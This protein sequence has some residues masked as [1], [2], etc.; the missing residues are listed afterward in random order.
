MVKDVV[1]GSGG[2]GAEVCWRAIRVRKYQGRGSLGD[3]GGGAE[4]CWGA[5]RVE[6]YQGR[7]GGMHMTDESVGAHGECRGGPYL[8]S[9]GETGA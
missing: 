8:G 5:I 6:Q 2:G 7:G 3:Q 1:R 4:V 9:Y